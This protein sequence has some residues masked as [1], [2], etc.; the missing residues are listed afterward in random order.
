MCIAEHLLL[1]LGFPP[2][3]MR[4]SAK[5]IIPIT[6][7][8]LSPLEVK[9]VPETIH[10]FCKPCKGGKVFLNSYQTAYSD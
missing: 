8:R 10:P 9:V 5:V 6:C 7:S 2:L 4:S 3:I 1:L